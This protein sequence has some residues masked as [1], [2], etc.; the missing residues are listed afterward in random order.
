MNSQSTGLSSLYESFPCYRGT[1]TWEIFS[2][3]YTGGEPPTPTRTPTSPNFF[4]NS[5]QTPKQDSRFHGPYSPW[6]PSFAAAGSPDLKTPTRSSFGTSI[7]SPTKASRPPTGKDIEAEIASHVHHLSP[8]PSLPLPPV[9]PSRQLSSSPNPFS[10]SETKR[11][12]LNSTDPS[13]TPLR[14]T[15]DQEAGHS[16]NSAG[17]MQTPPPTS[18]SA[19]RRKAQQAQVARLVKASAEKERRMSYPG[20]ATVDTGEA[21][22]THVEESPNNFTSLQFS[23]DGFAFPM[24]GPA[25][26]PVYPQHKL[27]WDPEQNGDNMNTDFAMDDTFTA[28][29]GQKD[30]DPFGSSHIGGGISF[31]TS[32]A[33]NLLGNR[34]EQVR[35][36]T[37]ASH[38]GPSPA[39]ETSTS[40]TR[41]PSLR[42]VVNPSLLFS[43]PGRAAEASNMPSTSQ[44]IQ[45][46][47]LLPYAHQ[48][49]DAQMEMGLQMSRKPKR[50]RGPETDSPAVKAALQ[51]LRDDHAGIRSDIAEDM[52]ASSANRR[53][54]SRNSSGRSKGNSAAG[55]LPLHKNRSKSRLHLAEDLSQQRKR[56]SVTFTIDA[57]GRAR[58]EA[59]VLPENNKRQMDIGSDCGSENSSSSSNDEMI[60]SQTQSF[61]YSQKQMQPK[62]GRFTHNSQSHSQKSSYASTMGSGNNA[63]IAC[64]ST[65]RRPS[66]SLFIQS[67]SQD[68]HPGATF[69]SRTEHD[70]ESEAETVINSEDDRGDAQSAL[71]KVLQS[72]QTKASK[73]STGPGTKNVYVPQ[74]RN[75]LPQNVP[76]H[77]YYMSESLTPTRGY[78]D[79]YSNISPTTITDPD[80]ATPS[81]AR[82]NISNDSVRCLCQMSEDDGQ[83]M[84]QWYV[85]PVTK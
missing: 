57:N 27:F 69:N 8:N 32:P 28:F 64:E 16:M 38:A 19:S 61:T 44:E 79:P 50:K 56:T 36:F 49:R 84:I 23:P 81:T 80:L 29:G 41:K 74:H 73:N 39:T 18:T 6:S 26:A 9:E 70:D 20:I 17:S 21:S 33:F 52:T 14:T 22:A 35:P 30:S 66:S 55:Q 10:N 1:L 82:S 5:F 51:T 72:R 2:F 31:P 48:L 7:R 67:N 62:L 58:T 42:K 46:D 75:Y 12:R 85:G 45:D 37:S 34:V 65:S 15:F 47:N 68:Y 78:N 13:I 25:T 59:K 83:L 11:R 43:S 4:L 53:P 40:M 77:P 24:S 76:P 60:M 3:S 71:K 63:R 54:S